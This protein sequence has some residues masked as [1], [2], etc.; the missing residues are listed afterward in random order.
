MPECTLCQELERYGIICGTCHSVTWFNYD[1][2]REDDRARVHTPEKAEA[3]HANRRW[4]H[5]VC[6]EYHLR[7]VWNCSARRVSLLPAVLRGTGRVFPGGRDAQARS[8]W[9][10]PDRLLWGTVRAAADEPTEDKLLWQT[11]RDIATGRRRII[12]HSCSRYNVTISRSYR[13]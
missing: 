9:P 1:Q 10:Q 11:L 5:A 8:Q 7:H 4:L 6:E 13:E 12:D 3:S 2:T